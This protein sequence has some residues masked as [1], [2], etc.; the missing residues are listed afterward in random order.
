MDEAHEGIAGNG[1]PPRREL[2]PLTFSAAAR[3]SRSVLL[4]RAYQELAAAEERED[5]AVVALRIKP[6]Q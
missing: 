3:R 4:A 2:T 1:P 6:A 5:A